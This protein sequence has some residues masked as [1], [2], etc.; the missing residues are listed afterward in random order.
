MFCWHTLALPA[1]SLQSY[2]AARMVF[3]LSYPLATKF[4]NAMKTGEA[5]GVYRNSTVL[6]SPNPGTL[7]SAPVLLL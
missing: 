3:P 5:G 4:T 6:V 2:G 7:T 1:A